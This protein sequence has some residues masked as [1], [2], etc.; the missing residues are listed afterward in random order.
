ML[1]ETPALDL[2]LLRL[3]LAAVLSG[4]I[5]WER[6]VHGRAAGLRTTILVGVGSCLVMMTSIRMFEM[7]QGSTNVDPGRIAAQVVS[8]IG[9][10]GAGTIIRSGASIRG[11]TTAAGIWAV[12]GV[13][14][15][16]GSGYYAAAILTTA[17]IFLVLATLARIEHRLQRTR[18]R[19]VQIDVKDGIDR[20]SAFSKILEDNCIVTR[21][22]RVRLDPDTHAYRIEIKALFPVKSATTT[23]IT[24]QLASMDGVIAV[25]WF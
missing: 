20:L 15:A 11:L 16:V 13:G 6:E 17:I 2:L 12:A 3:L 14:L 1:L 5:G 25:Q 7:F 9:F 10:L 24:Q 8:G 19:I 21:D 23:G 4:I 18:E 22:I